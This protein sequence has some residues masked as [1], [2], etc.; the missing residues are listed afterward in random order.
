MSREWF[1]AAWRRL[2][3]P[4]LAL[5]LVAVCRES[6]AADGQRSPT[7]RVRIE[8]TADAPAVW[9]GRLTVAGGRF[10]HPQSLGSARDDAGTISLD[11]GALL[12]RRHSPRQSDA[13]EVNITAAP[14]SRLEFELR[15]RHG[16]VPSHTI[17]LVLADCLHK[18]RAFPADGNRPRVVVRRAAGDSLAV[19]IDRPHLVFDPEETFRMS[20][21]LN[22][23]DPRDGIDKPAR[24]LLKWKLLPAEGNRS[25]VEG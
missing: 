6:A 22:L 19:T 15:D 7:V 3:C 12:L 25:L 8:W 17:H 13:F 18:P 21:A 4:V 20:I 16:S 2:F 10:D 9:T 14:D 5:A 1:P 11:R 23:L 24:A